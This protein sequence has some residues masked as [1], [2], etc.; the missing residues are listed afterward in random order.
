M[1]KFDLRIH[2]LAMEGSQQIGC[3][4]KGPFQDRHNQKITKFSVPDIFGNSLNTGAYLVGRV[5]GF[6]FV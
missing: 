4:H 3:E 5:K 1:N 2:A 6:D